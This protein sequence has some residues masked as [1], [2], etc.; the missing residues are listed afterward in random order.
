MK[1]F[2][3]L[4]PILFFLSPPSRSLLLSDRPAAFFVVETFPNDKPANKDK[5]DIE[6]VLIRGDTFE[7]GCTGEQQDCFDAEK[8]AHQVVLSDFYIGKYEVT[9]KQWLLVMGFNPSSFRNC[10]KRPVE[11]ISWYDVQEF[12]QKLNQ[13]LPAGQKPYRLLTEAEWEYAARGGGNAVLFGN[14]KNVADP[15]QI[16]FDSNWDPKPY[17]IVGI[18]RQKTTPVGSFSAN[19]LGLYD[20]S[21]NVWEWCNDWYDSY[22]SSLQINPTGPPS[23]TSRVVRGGS[24][25]YYPQACRVASR[26]NVRP[27]TRS[28]LVGFRLAR[29]L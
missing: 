3:L 8:P 25:F 20:M 26:L 27:D 22:S 23:G 16:N 24:W 29:S 17:S 11:N 7:M 6:L 14:G 28:Y 18:D 15:A 10:D 12:L 9:Q 4:M 19:P 21:G 1:S 5:F 13:T 2:W